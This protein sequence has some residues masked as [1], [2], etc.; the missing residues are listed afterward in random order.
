MDQL[1]ALERGKLIHTLLQRL[2]LQHESDQATSAIRYIKKQMPKLS[3]EEVTKLLGEVSDIL[4]HEECKDLF[5]KESLAEAAIIG[6]IGKLEI[7]GQ[8]DRLIV[9]DTHIKI[10]DFKT[11]RPSANPPQ[12]YLRQMALY[13]GLLKQLYP[14][15]SFHSFLI[16]TQTAEIM[17]LLNEQLNAYLDTIKGL[18]AFKD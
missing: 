3:E 11:G 7:S 15:R 14:G 10:A 8:I 17:P 16:W 5:S 12:T 1:K 4:H 18:K 9:T 2:P 6:K 13:M